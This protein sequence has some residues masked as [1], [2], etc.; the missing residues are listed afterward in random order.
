[1]H[2]TNGSREPITN[3]LLSLIPPS[4]PIVL[5]INAEIK[6]QKKLSYII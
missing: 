5:I 3:Y 4:P 6:K 1:M 2:K